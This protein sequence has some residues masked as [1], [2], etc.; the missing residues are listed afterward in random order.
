M[1]Q[2]LA[3]HCPYCGESI[4]LIVD[5]SSIEAPYIEDCEVCCR[6]MTIRV[7]EDQDGTL[8]VSAHAEDEAGYQ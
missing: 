6:P 8:S 4:E 2:T 3:S 7:S 1:L 5:H